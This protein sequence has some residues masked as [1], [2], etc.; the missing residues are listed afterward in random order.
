MRHVN[1]YR[2]MTYMLVYRNVKHVKWVY[3]DMTYVKLVL[4]Y[5]ACR[6]GL[7]W[8]SRYDACRVGIEI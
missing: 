3:R 8:V 1:G 2:Y 6:V 5:D 4:R 7:K